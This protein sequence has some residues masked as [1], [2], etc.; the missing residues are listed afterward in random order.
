MK[1]SVNVEWGTTSLTAGMWQ[2]I[3]PRAAFTGQM[4]RFIVSAVVVF[5]PGS[6]DWSE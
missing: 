1:W 4:D 6:C 3:Q 5:R 2:P